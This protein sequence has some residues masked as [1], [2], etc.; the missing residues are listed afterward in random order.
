MNDREDRS[1]PRRE[2]PSFYEKAV[3]IALGIIAVAVVVLLFI[4]LA[5]ALRLF[6][7]AG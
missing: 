7:G 1:S 3:P 5:V 4:I 6:P 2:Y